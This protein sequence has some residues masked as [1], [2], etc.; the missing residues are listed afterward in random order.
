MGKLYLVQPRVPC[1]H[2]IHAIFGETVIE[3][4]DAVTVRAGVPQGDDM[5]EEDAERVTSGCHSG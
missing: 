1:G 5:A 3:R 2:D 4:V